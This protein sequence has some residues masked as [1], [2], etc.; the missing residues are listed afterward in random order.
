MVQNPLLPT[1]HKRMF[2]DLLMALEPCGHLGIL[3][4]SVSGT[5]CV[6]GKI[7]VKV[8]GLL[9]IVIVHCTKDRN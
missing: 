7:D 6:L 1:H 3:I 8:F 5:I 9:S 4:P 2:L